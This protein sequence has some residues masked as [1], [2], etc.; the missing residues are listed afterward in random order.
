MAKW[1]GEN[2]PAARGVAAAAAAAVS[3]YGEN[4]RAI[5]IRRKC[6]AAKKRRKY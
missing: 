5:S 3:W 2:S 6:V 1:R 4:G